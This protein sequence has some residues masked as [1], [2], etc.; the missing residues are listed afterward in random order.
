MQGAEG[1]SSASLPFLYARCGRL[2]IRLPSISSLETPAVSGTNPCSEAVASNELADR[3][4]PLLT[5]NC[6]YFF[7]APRA[8]PLSPRD[9]AE[10][11]QRRACLVH[12]MINIA[13]QGPPGHRILSSLFQFSRSNPTRHLPQWECLLDAHL[14]MSKSSS[15]L[16]S[17]P[18]LSSPGG[19]CDSTL[20]AAAV[21]AVALL[22]VC[23]RTSI[24]PPNK[25]AIAAVATSASLEEAN[26]ER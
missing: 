22:S 1:Y 23:G 20:A 24:A 13:D 19:G 9:F 25:V 18:C 14:L 11:K 26:D 17:A 6:W 16:S 2:L 7:D 4:E 15:L 21:A 10:I 8:Q 3:G 5:R 12:A